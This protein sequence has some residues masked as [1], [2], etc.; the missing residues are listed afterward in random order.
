MNQC[1]DVPDGDLV[2]P[3]IVF[4]L[5]HK[6]ELVTL[7]GT[8]TGLTCLCSQS[9]VRFC[10]CGTLL[11]T[12][13][14]VFGADKPTVVVR[15]HGDG[16]IDDETRLLSAVTVALL[17][18]CKSVDKS[19]FFL[20]IRD[21]YRSGKDDQPGASEEGGTPPR[22]SSP[23]KKKGPVL[24]THQVKSLPVKSF[25]K[26]A[27]LKAKEAKHSASAQLKT[28]KGK[29]RRESK[30]ED[31][32]EPSPPPPDPSATPSTSASAAPG[33]PAPVAPPLSGSAGGVKPPKPPRPTVTGKPDV[34]PKPSPRKKLPATPPAF[35]KAE[36]AYIEDGASTVSG[37][38]KDTSGHR[39]D[40]ELSRL[41]H[42]TLLAHGFPVT[43]KTEELTNEIEGIVREVFAGGPSSEC[44][45]TCPPEFGLPDTFI[46]RETFVDNLVQNILT[47]HGDVVSL[48]KG[49]TAT[50]VLEARPLTTPPAPPKRGPP[51][52]AQFEEIVSSKPPKPPRKKLER[53][54]SQELFNAIAHQHELQ[55]RMKEEKDCWVKRYN[56]ERSFQLSQKKRTKER[57]AQ[58]RRRIREEIRQLR[59]AREEALRAEQIAWRQRQIEEYLQTRGHVVLQPA[60][61]VQALN[62]LHFRRE[63]SPSD[64]R[65]R[66]KSV[67]CLKS[68]SPARSV[69]PTPSR[70][71]SSSQSS[72]QRFKN[73][74]H[75]GA[76]T[77]TL[78]S[79][80]LQGA[81]Q[82]TKRQYKSVQDISTDSF[83]P[84]KTSVASTQASAP[85]DII[86]TPTLAKTK[87]P[88]A[89]PPAILRGPAPP[90]VPPRPPPR[91][92]SGTQSTVNL[93]Y[94]RP[95]EDEERE[96]T[97]TPSPSEVMYR[98]MSQLYSASRSI[99]RNTDAQSSSAGSTSTTIEIRP[100]KLSQYD[101]ERC[102]QFYVENVLKPLSK[103][104]PPPRPTPRRAGAGYTSDTASSVPYLSTDDVSAYETAAELDSEIEGSLRSMENVF[105]EIQESVSRIHERVHASDSKTT[106]SPP[107]TTGE[108]NVL[109]K[110]STVEGAFDH[111]ETETV[112][113]EDPDPSLMLD[114][115]SRCGDDEESLSTDR[116]KATGN[117]VSMGQRWTSRFG[118]E[119]SNVGVQV[120]ARWI[121]EDK[122]RVSANGESDFVT[123][124]KL[125]LNSESRDGRFPDWGRGEGGEES[126]VDRGSRGSSVVSSVYRRGVDVVSSNGSLSTL[127]S[128]STNTLRS[129]SAEDDRCA[130]DEGEG[131]PVDVVD[132]RSGE[133]FGIRSRVRRILRS[134]GKG[135]VGGR[136]RKGDRRF[137]T[138]PIVI[139]S[140]DGIYSGEFADLSDSQVSSVGVQAD[141]EDNDVEEQPAMASKGSAQILTSIN[142]PAYRYRKKSA[143]G[144]ENKR[145]S[146]VE[147]AWAER[148]L[149]VVMLRVP[150]NG[151]TASLSTV[152]SDSGPSDVQQHRKT[153][154]TV[155]EEIIECERT[156]VQSLTLL[157]ESFLKPLLHE[158]N[159]RN[160]M[161]VSPST[162]E[163]IFKLIPQLQTLHEEILKDLQSK[164]EDPCH[165]AD[166]ILN[167]GHF[168]R[169]YTDYVCSHNNQ[170]RLL[171]DSM[172]SHP[173]FRELVRKLE[174]ENLRYLKLEDFF[175]KP[176]QKM[177]QFRLLLEKF[178]KKCCDADVKEH[179]QKAHDFV[180]KQILSKCQQALELDD[181]LARM[182]NLQVRIRDAPCE[183]IQP[184]RKLLRE[185][186]LQKLCRKA[187]QTRYFILFSDTLW[188]TCYSANVAAFAGSAPILSVR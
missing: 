89:P 51:A 76:S 135:N 147:K 26:S 123:K 160:F 163:Q 5:S 83:D 36:I 79:K 53:S 186:E 162:V 103:P 40:P 52:P 62:S 183:V 108:S 18:F 72:K 119:M 134:F 85:S 57:Q 138:Q 21:P 128:R 126:G 150:S 7:P 96:R 154:T 37:F 55:N 12:S 94:V 64:L 180:E 93:S 132:R 155:M 66:S 159:R 25:L 98:S 84:E 143:G 151:S 131:G 170:C 9:D 95:R 8:W 114:D 184:R 92:K 165:M 30:G 80:S 44:L 16:T 99:P 140:D 178:L 116:P 61:S 101:L 67:S 90:P 29:F 130:S 24:K 100:E 71:R 102:H 14:L 33:P 69:S 117:D 56:E 65:G 41:I 172:E 179:V 20:S 19:L 127:S 82:R 137:F 105:G 91:R 188:H 39:P 112:D 22:P 1:V 185:G 59:E 43:A 70:S 63:K 120:Q 148:A 187:P 42:N 15:C 81:P 153:F 54:L 142:R 125:A 27:K 28:A 113:T 86:M 47:S 129:I 158:A 164:P 73:R 107:R 161:F 166:V 60:K 124:K 58:E 34:P 3:L 2:V 50:S 133:G 149:D 13:L 157:N 48:G 97:V 173:K 146:M 75:L 68:G 4:T 111:I 32:K 10:F 171:S 74:R 88:V 11:A 152:S 175:L 45:I 145:K 115:E 177:T 35:R 77:A 17:L 6:S 78:T 121:G 122:G 168:F 38:R 46:D 87:E 109:M 31:E 167:K 182:W 106:A 176:V 118:L 141:V 49:S 144:M 104:Q 156:Y 169:L 23:A 139:D 136:N 181:H 110:D 174:A